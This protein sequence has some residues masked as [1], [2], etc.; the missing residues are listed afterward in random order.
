MEQAQG[1]D[2][3][4]S[5][6]GAILKYRFYIGLYDLVF[7]TIERQYEE[8]LLGLDTGKARLLTEQTEP[9]LIRNGLPSFHGEE[10]DLLDFDQYCSFFLSTSQ[11]GIAM[12]NQKL[13]H[14]MFRLTLK[15][16]E[17]QTQLRLPEKMIREKLIYIIKRPF[18]RKWTNSNILKIA[19]ELLSLDN[20]FRLKTVHNMQ[21]DQIW[22]DR[23]YS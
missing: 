11:Q 13:R 3:K 1:V 20:S 19:K 2:L 9:V 6:E 7:L 17:D 21:Q 4:K 16:E 10:V 12:T 5:K 15:I 14:Y 18:L 22:E 8:F 23:R